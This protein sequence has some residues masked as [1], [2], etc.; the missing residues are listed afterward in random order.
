MQRESGHSILI[1]AEE[2]EVVKAS[3]GLAKRQISIKVERKMR[4]EE[5]H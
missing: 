1:T 2:M 5:M 3:R 4:S